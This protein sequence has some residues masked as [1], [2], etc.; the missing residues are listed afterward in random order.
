MFNINLV[1]K[2][3]FLTKFNLLE[4]FDK[5][6]INSIDSYYDSIFIFNDI[7]W[8]NIVLLFKNYGIELYGGSDN[9]R[10]V[11]STVQANLVK[12]LMLMFNFNLDNKLIYN[13]YNATDNIDKKINYNLLKLFKTNGHINN[14][15]EK[16]FS[17]ILDENTDNFYELNFKNI[18]KINLLIYYFSRIQ[19]YYNE[20][21]INEISK[22]IQTNENTVK[23]RLSRARTDLKKILNEG[24]DLE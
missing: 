18:F 5:E 16:K 20:L 22:L 15:V 23:S 21:T 12:F 11:I 10:H 13:S 3:N 24:N 9:R 14:D 17:N 4:H 8:K 2:L 6:N 1:N 19:Y 7:S